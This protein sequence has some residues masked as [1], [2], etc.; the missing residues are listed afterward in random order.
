MYIKNRVEYDRKAK[1]WT[2]TYA[3]PSV[4]SGKIQRVV[5]M[6]FE[7]EKAVKAL[8]ENEWDEEK[9]VNALLGM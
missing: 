8:E 4:N 5:E 2:D 7:K 1:E 6:G 9:A 3:N